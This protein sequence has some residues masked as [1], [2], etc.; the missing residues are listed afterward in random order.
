MGEETRFWAG[1]RPPNVTGQL[2]QTLYV[3]SYYKMYPAQIRPPKQGCSSCIWHR[4]TLATA[5]NTASP[6]REPVLAGVYSIVRQQQGP[7][8]D[9][10]LRLWCA[11]SAYRWRRDRSPVIYSPA[12]VPAGTNRVLTGRCGRQSSLS[13][14]GTDGSGD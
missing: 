8:S 7:E 12:I 5:R 1:K 14:A 9:S 3:A 10:K 2:P 13:N 4:R 6:Q 11:A